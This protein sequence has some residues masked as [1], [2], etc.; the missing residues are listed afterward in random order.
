MNKNLSLNFGNLIRVVQKYI[1]QIQLIDPIE[2]TGTW[3]QPAKSGFSKTKACTFLYSLLLKDGQIS[4]EH[5]VTDQEAADLVSYLRTEVNPWVKELAETPDSTLILENLKK[6]CLCKMDEKQQKLLWRQ[7]QS[8]LEK[9]DFGLNDAYGLR[10]FITAKFSEMHLQLLFGHCFIY[11]LSAPNTELQLTLNFGTL[12]YLIQKYG[13]YIETDPARE[14]AASTSLTQANVCTFLYALPLSD[15]QISKAIQVKVRDANWLFYHRREVDQNV[16]DSIQNANAHHLILRNLEYR[17]FRYMTPDQKKSLWSQLQS[18]IQHAQF[19]PEN[20]FGLTD[21]IKMNFSN[22]NLC[23]LVS[24]CFLYCV[25]FSNRDFNAQNSNQVLSPASVLPTLEQLPDYDPYSSLGDYRANSKALQFSL[26]EPGKTTDFFSLERVLDYIKANHL[27]IYKLD[28]QDQ[29]LMLD[30]R[31]LPDG[32]TL[33]RL[34]EQDI[35]Q[36]RQAVEDHKD[37]FRNKVSWKGKE[38]FEML[39][40]GLK[41]GV[42]TAYGYRTPSGELAAY[43][44]YKIRTDSDLELGIQLTDPAYRKKHIASSLVYLFMLMFADSRVVTGTYEE[45]RG[46]RKVLT[47]C[48]FKPHVFYDPV[49]KLS[50]SYIRER[51][52][53][54]YPDDP[55]ARSNSVYYES[56]SLTSKI[57]EKSVKTII[58]E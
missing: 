30:C 19:D 41:S 47:D 56:S 22:E 11:C 10:D 16:K 45:N 43:L 13:A 20:S 58:S 37:E 52:N 12:A 32:L 36:A 9:T 44:D 21:C 29:A 54:K 46:M 28:C 24:K 26:T 33:F 39:D 6:R 31:P 35:E 40:N 25:T 50:T 14:D 18:I 17:Y 27:M 8:M 53:P 34:E 5:K 2:K 23:I 7:L 42:W 51:I 49:N 38:L 4:E 3:Y 15:Q 55:L 1:P 48:G 57:W